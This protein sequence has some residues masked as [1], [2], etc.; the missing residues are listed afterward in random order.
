MII[1]NLY[2]IWRLI[3]QKYTNCFSSILFFIRTIMRHADVFDVHIITCVILSEKCY[4]TIYFVNLVKSD[5][6]SDNIVFVWQPR[7]IGWLL[8]ILLQ[9][10]YFVSHSSASK[11]WLCVLHQYLLCYVW[12]SWKPWV[13]QCIFYAVLPT[14]RTWQDQLLSFSKQT[15]L[16]F[17]LIYNKHNRNKISN[18]FYWYLNDDLMFCYL[19]FYKLVADMTVYM[20]V[21]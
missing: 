6:T 11:K 18:E 5:A 16:L 9:K 1:A 8:C 20:L 13:C 17:Y 12:Y 21:I 10:W 19:C 7:L 2:L 14:C 4:K 15:S 3:W